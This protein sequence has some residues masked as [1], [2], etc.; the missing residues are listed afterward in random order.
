MRLWFSTT[1]GTNRIDFKTED[2][3]MIQTIPLRMNAG[4]IDQL[5]DHLGLG[6][7]PYRWTHDKS[8]GLNIAVQVEEGE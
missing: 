8:H 5:L 6:G 4:V 7:K 2:S 3:A 1:Q